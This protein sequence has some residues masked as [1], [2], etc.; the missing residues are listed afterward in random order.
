MKIFLIKEGKEVG[1]FTLKQ[2]QQ[3]IKE[4]VVPPGNLA[5]REG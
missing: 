2:V 5:W 4:G 3:W 1:P